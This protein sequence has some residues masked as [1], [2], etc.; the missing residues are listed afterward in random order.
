MPTV[1]GVILF[2]G[3]GAAARY[4]LER[5]LGREG[6]VFPWGTF[7]AN[8]T[9]SLL[10]GVLFAVTTERIEISSWLRTSLAIGLLGGYTTFSTFSLQTHRLLEDGAYGLAV[11]YTLGSVLAGLAAAALGVAIVRLS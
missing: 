7:T 10:L 1:L 4:G 5:W 6:T 3:V 8:V 11:A 9:G 2:G